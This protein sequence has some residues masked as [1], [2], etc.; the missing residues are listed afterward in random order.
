MTRDLFSKGATSEI[1]TYAIDEANRGA[2]AVINRLAKRLDLETVAAS[3][4]LADTHLR[5]A[6]DNR[7]GRNMDIRHHLSALRVAT[8]AE[9]LAWLTEVAEALGYKP[10]PIKPRTDT[11]RL[12]DLEQRVVERY[13]SSGAE[14]VESERAKP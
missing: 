2:K 11:E 7:E 5:Q 8:D 12:R 9:R 6:L 1:S 10:A 3:S 14:L 13:G 4:G